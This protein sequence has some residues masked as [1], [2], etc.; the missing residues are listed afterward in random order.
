M[1]REDVGV[2]VTVAVVATTVVVAVG[3]VVFVVHELVVESYALA[4][5]G[6]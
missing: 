5:C 3:M 2:V 6:C 1:W 4:V